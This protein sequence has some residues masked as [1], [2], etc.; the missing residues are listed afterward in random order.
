MKTEEDPFVSELLTDIKYIQSILKLEAEYWDKN[1]KA[2]ER[3]NNFDTAL[4]TL[5]LLV[6]ENNMKASL[7]TFK[8]YN[9]RVDHIR[10]CFHKSGPNYTRKEEVH[11][12]LT[13]IL[14]RIHKRAREEAISF[15]EKKS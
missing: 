8:E 3:I 5:S 9:L 11:F 1:Q 4:Y 10:A 13:D 14:F 15:T 12:R 7:L 6:S 2:A